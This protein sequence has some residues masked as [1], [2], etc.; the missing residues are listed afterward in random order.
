MRR[1]GVLVFLALSLMLAGQAFAQKKA[2]A[3]ASSGDNSVYF[4]TYYANAITAA[5]DE[6]VRLINDGDTGGTLWASIYAFDDSQEL[7]DCCSCAV[8]ADG[9]LSESVNL[10]LVN[11]DY[12]L[13]PVIDHRGVIKIISSSTA[14][15]GP[16]YTNTP[17]PGLRGWATHS[18]SVA[19]QYPYGP[20]AYSQTETPLADSNLTSGEQSM[21]ESLCYY[22]QLLGSG[23][24]H[25]TCTPEDYDF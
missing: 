25:C 10:Q 20:A 9:L 8:S 22:A 12:V 7:Q 13:M 15:G 23:Y 14:A 17:T 3:A 18:Q 1:S 21:L 6:T 11:P 2:A 5:P 16:S 4:T 19:N 24:G